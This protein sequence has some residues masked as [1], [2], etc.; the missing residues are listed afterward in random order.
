MWIVEAYH[1]KVGFFDHLKI[2]GDKFLHVQ[3]GLAIWCLAALILKRPLRSPLPI[4][5]VFAA[6]IFN[7]IMDRLHAGNWRWPD[8]IGDAVST[9]FWPV[10]LCIL[11]NAS[12]RFRR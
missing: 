12:P 2:G 4:A 1:R 10:L 3:A 5:I 9:W 8:T 11:L 6:E 7:E